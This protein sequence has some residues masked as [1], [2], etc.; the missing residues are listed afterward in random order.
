MNLAKLTATTALFCASLFMV[1]CEKD[2]YQDVS[3]EYRKSDIP[4]TGAQQVPATT[5]TGLGKL[6]VS[7]SKKTKVLV[8]NFNWTG[9][10]DTITGIS[11][12]GPAPTGFNSAT[13]KQ[14]LPGFSSSLIANQTAY[15]Y[16]NSSYSGSVVVDDVV[17][18]ETDLLNFMYYLNIRT[19]AFPTG[20]IRAQIRFQ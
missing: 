13:I 5:S 1:S 15:P 20:E 7:Y 8:Y 3:S 14:A 6:N 17:I 12:H 19:K 9:L 10:R 11:I 18:K 4:I 16:Q 2:E